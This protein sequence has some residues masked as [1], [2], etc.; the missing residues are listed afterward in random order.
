MVTVVQTEA[1]VVATGEVSCAGQDV[2][3][4]VQASTTP[5]MCAARRTARHPV[6]RFL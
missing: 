6:A 1:A 3:L 4:F 5:H 2:K